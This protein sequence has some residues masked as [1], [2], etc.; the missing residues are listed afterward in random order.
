[1]TLVGKDQIIKGFNVKVTFYAQSIFE[2][3]NYLYSNSIRFILTPAL[4]LASVKKNKSSMSCD[5]KNI[6]TP[7]RCFVSARVTELNTFNFDGKF[8]QFGQFFILLTFFFVSICDFC[9]TCIW[10][11]TCIN[12]YTPK[13]VSEQSSKSYFQILKT[14]RINE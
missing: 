11:L 13:R 4:Q 6:C 14:I 12:K 2:H 7:E 10:G 9:M 1:M 5:M 8:H 3:L